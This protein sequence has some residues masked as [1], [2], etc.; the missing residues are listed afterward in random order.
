MS[1][2]VAAIIPTRGRPQLAAGAVRS[3]LRQ[4]YT[5]IGV[6]V[7][8]DGSDPPLRLPDD[9][10]ADERV[11]IIRCHDPVKPAAARNL[12]AK[13]SGAELLAFLDD[14]DEWF[15]EKTALQVAALDAGDPGL[16][17]VECGYEMRED[18]EV[19]FRYL[20]NVN[21]ELPQTLLK[22]PCMQPSTL[23]VCA[24]VFTELGGFSHD[25]FR[26]EDWDFSIRLADRYRVRLLPQILVM[27]RTNPTL[28]RDGAL[29]AHR[30][31]VKRLRPRIQRLAPAERRATIGYHRFVEGIY[32][33][34]MGK[35]SAARTAL[36]EAWRTNPRAYAPL[37]HLGRT[38]IG[39][40]AW[41]VVRRY[42]RR[43]E[44]RWQR[45]RGRDPL[46][47]RW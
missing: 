10:A 36:W 4:T 13:E 35:T 7:V 32:L 46:V 43:A 26:V 3:A 41:S 37:A 29:S 42:R 2:R 6:W 27:R 30:D 31:M 40:R 33:A 11:R 15:P 18:G 25:H 39:E 17:A 9:L 47:R 28:D 20:P 45:S 44:T 21:R 12:A 38:L 5:D 24:D 34:E 19:M 22:V 23:M 14:D 1:P 8:D 16:A